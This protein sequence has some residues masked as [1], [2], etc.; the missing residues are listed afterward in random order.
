MLA[1]LNQKVTKVEIITMNSEYRAGTKRIWSIFALPRKVTRIIA[2]AKGP[3]WIP[4]SRAMVLAL[5][6]WTLIALAI[7]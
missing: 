3:F 4:V 6:G 2:T 7:R 1:L 5:A